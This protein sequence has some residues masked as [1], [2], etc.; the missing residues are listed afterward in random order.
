[1]IGPSI[2]IAAQAAAPELYKPKHDGDE[3]AADFVNKTFDAI[4]QVILRDARS[5]D[6]FATGEPEPAIQSTDSE[7]AP[8]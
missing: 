5:P 1:M 3:T 4:D 6:R 2:L 7:T 8:R